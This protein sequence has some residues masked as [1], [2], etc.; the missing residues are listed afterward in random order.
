M[1]QFDSDLCP[2]RSKVLRVLLSW[3]QPISLVRRRL[4]VGRRTRRVWKTHIWSTSS[5]KI[6]KHKTLEVLTRQVCSVL[7]IDLSIS[8]CLSVYLSIYLS[9]YLQYVCTSSLLSPL[10]SLLSPLLT[11]PLLFSSLLF[12]SLLSLYV[13]LSVC[14]LDLPHPWWWEVH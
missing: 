11:S 12:S 4:A 3:L 6:V 13:C 8:V 10:S 9:I 14:L 1:R 7:E 5:D 2:G